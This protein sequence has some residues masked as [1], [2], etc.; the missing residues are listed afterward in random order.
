MARE[1]ETLRNQREEN[2]VKSTASPDTHIDSP[3]FTFAQSGLAVVTDFGS[4]EQYRIGDFTIDRN[5]TV[6][7]FKVQVIFLGL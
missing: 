3:D 1:L 6:D 5:D 2:G 7:M 4:R